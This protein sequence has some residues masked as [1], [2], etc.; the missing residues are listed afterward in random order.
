MGW[1]RIGLVRL[2]YWLYLGLGSLAM[3]IVSLVTA[4]WSLAALSG[5]VLALAT[6]RLVIL[7]SDP[8]E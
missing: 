4:I 8:D 1:R 2:G 7:H 6:W 3:L 5:I